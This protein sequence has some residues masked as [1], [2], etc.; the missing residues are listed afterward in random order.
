MA[1]PEKNEYTPA[2]RSYLNPVEKAKLP[3]YFE[4]IVVTPKSVTF[5]ESQKISLNV[6]PG[7]END[8]KLLI[9]QM[10]VRGMS[11]YMQSSLI[12]DMRRSL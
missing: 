3:E 11:H 5:G 2:I 1:N 12:A 4:K 9:S 10:I 6:Q 8:I 7:M